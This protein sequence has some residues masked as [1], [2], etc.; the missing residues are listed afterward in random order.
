MSVLQFTQDVFYTVMNALLYP[1][2]FF[3][4]FSF[5][6]IL[7]LFG[8]FM[9]EFFFRKK[10]KGNIEEIGFEISDDVAS[11]RFEQASAK[12]ER[13][14]QFWENESVMLKDFLRDLGRE[15]RKGMKNLDI[16]IESVLQE[17]EM[18]TAR[19]LDIT[20]VFI[21]LG[22][23]VGLMGTLIPIG[24]ALLSLSVGDITEMSNGLIIAFSTT[25]I[26]LVVGG[27][28]YVISVVRERWYESDMKAMEFLAEMIVR[29]LEVSGSEV[30]Q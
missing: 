24:G 23:M 28:A 7:Y 12:I 15:I 19:L 26:G 11:G 2:M 20:K 3:L 4:L 14:L 9:A 17:N 30:E 13:Y 27:V 10:C 1:V 16:R 18:R 5:A 25:V 6:F 8:R 22:P 29:E 21:R